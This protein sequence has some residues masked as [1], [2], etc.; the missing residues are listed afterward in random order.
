MT[1]ITSSPP[2]MGSEEAAV[3]E[4]GENSWMLSGLFSSSAVVPMVLDGR[5]GAV[6]VGDDGNQSPEPEPG[7][8]S[9]N[10]RLD[11]PCICIAADA[12][13]TALSHISSKG[14]VIRQR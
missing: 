8:A 14:R 4:Q 12:H 11:K 10:G 5:W 2:K 1:R 9:P 13:C 3:S 7:R 6:A